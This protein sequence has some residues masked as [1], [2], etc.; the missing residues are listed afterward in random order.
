VAI[1]TLNEAENLSAGKTRSFT[2]VCTRQGIR[3]TNRSARHARR[4]RK[5]AIITR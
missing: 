4:A 1:V 5:L 2:A 3:I